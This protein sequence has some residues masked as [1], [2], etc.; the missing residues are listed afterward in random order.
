ME[1]FLIIGLTHSDKLKKKKKCFK[2]HACYLA[3][4]A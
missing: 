2:R 4:A 1:F 3:I